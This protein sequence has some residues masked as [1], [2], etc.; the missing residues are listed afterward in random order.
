[1]PKQAGFEALISASSV[2]KQRS[3]PRS[4]RSRPIGNMSLEIEATDVIKIIL[5]FCKENGL[6]ESFTCL[7][8]ECQV[9]LN[10]VDSIETFVADINNGRWDVVLPQVSQLKL[11][12]GKLEDLYE[13]VRCRSRH[14]RIL[15]IRKW[16]CTSCALR[17]GQ[18]AGVR[19]SRGAPPSAAWQQH[20]TRNS[21]RCMRESVLDTY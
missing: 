15:S 3:I 7:Q 4:F 11:P 5:Q 9:S 6:T 17:A 12:R 13:Q 18:H 2:H 19:G 14:C 1:M 10:T 16:Y 20:P 8:N 21:Y